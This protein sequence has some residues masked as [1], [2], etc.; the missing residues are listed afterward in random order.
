VTE[1]LFAY[2]LRRWLPRAP[3]TDQAHQSRSDTSP[4]TQLSIALGRAQRIRARK[5]STRADHGWVGDSIGEGRYNDGTV[6]IWSL[7]FTWYG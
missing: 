1:Q 2:I 3:W 4:A 7:Y 6:K 5:T